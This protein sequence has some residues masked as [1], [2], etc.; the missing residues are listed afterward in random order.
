MLVRSKINAPQFGVRT[1]HKSTDDLPEITEGSPQ[2]QMLDGAHKHPVPKQPRFSYPND[3]CQSA[4][5]QSSK[6]PTEIVPEPEKPQ[7]PV[8]VRRKR[9]M[10][11]H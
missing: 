6:V 11:P 8:T 3:L 2:S 7:V 5:P 10:E 4:G 1:D 9:A